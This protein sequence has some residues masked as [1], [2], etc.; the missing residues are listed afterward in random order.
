MSQQGGDD[1]CWYNA[2]IEEATAGSL[3][4]EA[5]LREATIRRQFT[6]WPK[7]NLATGHITWAL[8]R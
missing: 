8:K 4:L 6:I 7:F 2:A 5:E 1:T 3:Q